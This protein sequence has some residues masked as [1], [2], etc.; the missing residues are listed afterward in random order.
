MRQNLKWY[1]L[2]FSQFL[3]AFA[4][5]AV[6]FALVGILHKQGIT[7][8]DNKMAGYQLMFLL[9]YVILAPIVGALADRNP[10]R[11]ILM[12]GNLFKALGALLLFTNIDPGLAYGLVGVGAVIYSPAKYG[13]L[14]EFTD[15]KQKLLTANGI[16]EGTT[17]LAIL[18]GTVVGGMMA[19]N[20]SVQANLEICALIYIVALV[21]AIVIPRVAGNPAIHYGTSATG[22]FKEVN[23][24]LKNQGA[25]FS[26]FGTASFW[27][28][29]AVIRIGFLTWLADHLDITETSKQSMMVGTTAVGVVAGAMLAPLLIKTHQTGRVRLVGFAIGLSVIASLF[30]PNV[31]T[32]I[33]ALILIGVLGGLYVVP[34]NTLLQEEGKPLVGIGKTIAIQNFI[35]NIFMMVGVGLFKVIR[36]GDHPMSINLSLTIVS[37]MFIAIVILLSVRKRQA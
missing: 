6:F 37:V 12:L 13:I 11:N 29:S 20:L 8:T 18:L 9:A 7:D 3:S 33:T 15:N 1:S 2:Y 19:D 17:I 32:I 16:M 23:T 24:L 22:F 35:E 5:N 14:S 30:S 10:K 28:I 36:S 31:P 25:R 26:L 34:M 4:D 21:M 27:M